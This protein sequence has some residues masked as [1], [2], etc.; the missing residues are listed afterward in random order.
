[1]LPPLREIGINQVGG[2]VAAAKYVWKRL[3]RWSYTYRRCACRSLPHDLRQEALISNPSISA[4]TLAQKNALPLHPNHK[5][6]K[7][8][9]IASS[10]QPLVKHLQDIYVQY[11]QAQAA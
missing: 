7:G 5:W 2:V 4:T 6:W 9:T 1:M 10:T 3:T 8:V 11:N